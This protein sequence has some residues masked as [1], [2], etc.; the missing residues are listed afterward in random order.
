MKLKKIYTV[1]YAML[2]Y[3]VEK[4]FASPTE[5]KRTWLDEWGPMDTFGALQ[6]YVQMKAT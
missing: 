4:K 3:M 6:E 2:S 1:Q 5:Y